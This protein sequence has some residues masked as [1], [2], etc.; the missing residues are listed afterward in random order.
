MRT[1]KATVTRKEAESVFILIFAALWAIAFSV[2][3]LAVPPGVELVFKEGPK[4]VFFSGQVHADHGLK[5][6]DCH[7]GIFKQKQGD[8]HIEFADHIAGKKYCFACHNG[9][10]AFAT[11]KNCSKCHGNKSLLT[12]GPKEPKLPVTLEE[13]EAR[14]AE[15]AKGSY[16]YAGTCLS[17]HDETYQPP[18]FPIF[19][20]KHAALTDPRAPFADKQ[21]EACHGPGSVHVK[22]KKRRGG[23]II[24]F[25]KNAWTPVAEQ[26]EKCLACHQTHQRIE[27]KGSTHEFNGLACASCH[28]IHAARDPVLDREEQATVCFTCHKNKQA[29]FYQVSHHPVREGQMACSECHNVHGEDGTGLMVKASSREKC[30]SCHAEKRGPFLWEHAPAA[31][32]CTICHDPHG[33]NQPALLKKRVPQLCQE[34]HDPE[35]HPGGRYDGA[36]LAGGS[37]FLQAKG[38]LNCHSAIHGSNHPSGMTLLR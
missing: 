31:E 10:K 33:S 8:A 38:C 22:A 27:W 15:L 26:N 21:C 19:K 24:A 34:C 20:T 18:I 17:C 16:K 1:F 23:T 29:K 4:P 2:R 6:P 36:T 7:T 11:K 28:Q 25:G 14:I 32:D 37:A 12:A 30:T 9:T 13:K 35:G 5:C 3:A